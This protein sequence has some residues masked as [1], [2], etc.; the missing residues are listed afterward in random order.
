MSKMF[1]LFI[2]SLVI[3]WI[4]LPAI[5]FGAPVQGVLDR[6]ALKVRETARCQCV[7]IDVTFTD[8]RLVAVG[9][10]GIIIYS[11]DFGD[12]WEQA[13]VPVSVTLTAVYFPS[14]Q[15]GWA[16]G[17]GG[18]VL[19]TTDGGKTWEKQFDGITAAHMALENAQAH[20]ERMGPED[21][22]AQQ[23]VNNAVL[24]VEDLED[25][26]DKPLLDLY[27]KNDLEGFIIGSYGLIFRT[28]DGGDTWKCLMDSVENP[29]GLNL[30]SLSV[31]GDNMYIAAEQGLFL[32]SRDNGNSFQSIETPYIGTY[33]DLAISP[34]GEI[35]LVGLNGNAYWSADQG[36]TFNKSEVEVEVSFTKAAPLADGTLIF[37]NQGGMLL[38]SHDQ[39]RTIH[40]IDT[41]RLDPVSSFVPL[42]NNSIMTVGLGGAN[43][44]QLPSSGSNDK[45]GRP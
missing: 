37:S 21:F 22:E 41:A 38:I 16:V 20:A 2:R 29:D 19:R 30:Y 28:E 40:L 15:K 31:N 6:P 10:R 7:M 35:V 43:R 39:G 17:H 34:S 4:V 12:T 5:A 3:G 18:V 27:F 13:D 36:L 23:M 45:G 42:D 9:E 25:G 33:F 32:V 1:R 44:V 14:P 11:D 26:P 24:L 8:G